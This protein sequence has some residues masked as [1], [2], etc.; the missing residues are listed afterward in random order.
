MV[1]MRFHYADETVYTR[2]FHDDHLGS[3]SVVTDEN[4]AVLERDSYDDWGKRRYADGT[5]DPSGSITSLTTN[6]YLVR[7]TINPALQRAAEIAL[8]D[9]LARYEASSG[10]ARFSGPEM[11]LAEA[12]KLATRR[13]AQ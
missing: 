7:S 13:K 8:Q 10:R 5:D 3:I 6:T 4:G 2:Y 9:G 1:G 11:N 12:I